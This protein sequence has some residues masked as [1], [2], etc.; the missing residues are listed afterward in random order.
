M[1][2]VKSNR[3]PQATALPA[4]ASVRQ[5]GHPSRVHCGALR[6]PLTG[7]VRAAGRKPT[8]RREG[9]SLAGSGR[10]AHTALM[11]AEARAQYLRDLREE[12]CLAPKAV[13]SALLTEAEKRTRLARKVI[14]RKLNH[15]ETLVVRP[16]R[17][18]KPRYGAA[19]AAALAELWKLFDYPCGQRL[20]A[21]LREQVPRLRQRGQWQCSEQ[22]AAQLMTLS[23]KTAD[24]LLAPQRQRL[25]LPSRRG[26]PPAAG[27]DSAEGGR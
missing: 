12:Y 7:P 9:Q 27:P 8:D 21:L 4:S 18:R 23:A 6:A 3:V 10:G 22:V 16:R 25:R 19:V 15:P 17:R 24:R 5:R 14:I 20:V 2:H 11:D 13:K 26:E 1:G